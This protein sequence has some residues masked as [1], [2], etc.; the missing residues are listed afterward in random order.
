MGFSIGQQNRNL[1]DK[2]NRPIGHMVVMVKNEGE[3]G[4]GSI[5]E[6]K[7]PMIIFHFQIIESLPKLTCRNR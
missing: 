2:I 4:W 5:L 1:K 6:Y 7:E 3:P